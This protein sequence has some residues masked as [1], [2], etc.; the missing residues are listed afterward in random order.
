MPAR[1]RIRVGRILFSAGCPKGAA[2]IL[3]R[4]APLYGSAHGSEGGSASF[5]VH[6]ER[7]ER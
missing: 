4:R 7:Q 6:I 1:T 3:W 2:D 5:L